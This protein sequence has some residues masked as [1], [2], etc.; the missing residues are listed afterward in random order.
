MWQ[1][2]SNRGGPCG[3]VG[4]AAAML[5]PMLPVRLSVRGFIAFVLEPEV[6]VQQTFLLKRASDVPEIQF[7]G[8]TAQSG[9]GQA[10]VLVED[11][12]TV[13]RQRVCRSDET[14]RTRAASKSVDLFL[15][16][17]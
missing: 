2:R 3:C 5:L 10:V 11:K 1:W 13:V 4:S 15:Y 8:L 7:E 14:H 12:I 17:R 6:Q 9:R 16:V